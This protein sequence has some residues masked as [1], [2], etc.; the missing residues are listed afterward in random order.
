[1]AEKMPQSYANHSRI[2]P[3]YHFVLSLIFLINLLAS[4]WQLFKH[5]GFSTGIAFLVALALIGVYFYARTFPLHV[6]DRLIRLEE[7]L[8][9]A[10][11]LPDDLKGR[12]G[13]LKES[14]LIG[15]RFAPDEEA[16]DLVR[17]ILDGQLTGLG[18]IKKAIK[19]WRPDYF[20]C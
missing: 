18:E 16:P 19:T 7:R 1:M 10:E 15:L 4:G 9:L 12:I 14:Q 5:P 20:R 3:V 11:I 17:Q 6:Q 13:E 8:R 2:V